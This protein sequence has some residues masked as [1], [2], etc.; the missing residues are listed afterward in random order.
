ML[1]LLLKETG[2]DVMGGGRVVEYFT[3]FEKE[4]RRL[5]GLLH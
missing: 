4:R 3:L 5:R 1:S 2:C